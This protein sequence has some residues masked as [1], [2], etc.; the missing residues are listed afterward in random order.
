MQSFDYPDSYNNCQP[1]P[2]NDAASVIDPKRRYLCRHVY[3][4]GHRCG[5]PALRG[6]NLCYYHL[7]SRRESPCANRGGSFSMPRID[8]RASV[9]LALFEI[10]SRI[11]GGDI[12]HKR[13]SILL[14]GLQIASSNLSRQEK[15]LADHPPQV[16]EITADYCLGDLAPIVEI[17]DPTPQAGLTEQSATDATPPAVAESDE[18]A[19][20]NADASLDEAVIPTQC[21]SEQKAT[22]TSSDAPHNPM[23]SLE[24]FH[25]CCGVEENCHSDTEPS[26][27]AESPHFAFA[28]PLYAL[29]EN[30]R[31]SANK[32]S[33][34]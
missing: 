34:P 8:D 19:A 30:A 18:T 16:E 26:E 4:D 29:G 22:C 6:Q 33:A 13:G 3:T 15:N 12:D 7:R 25:D 14:Y 28:A 24:Q 32:I 2:D 31:M 5:S 10:L 17:I 21:E 20:P 27:G 11:A 1:I 23:P 9:Q